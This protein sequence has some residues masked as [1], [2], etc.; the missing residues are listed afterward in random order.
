[1]IMKANLILTGWG[2]S[3]YPAAALPNFPLF[4]ASRMT[5]IKNNPIKQGMRAIRPRFVCIDFL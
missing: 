4:V 5:E 3:E 2:R 1:M